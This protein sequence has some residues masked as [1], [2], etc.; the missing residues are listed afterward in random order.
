MKLYC[1]HDS[2]A[3]FYL[4]PQMYRNAGEAMRAFE[5]SCKNKET[6]FY[7]FPKDFTLLEVASFNQDN[8][9]I[10]RHETHMILCSATEFIQ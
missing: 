3:G 1:V 4:P 6:N 5:I 9:L 10:E 2:K 8:G 7:Q